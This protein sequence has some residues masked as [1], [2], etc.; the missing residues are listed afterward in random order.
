MINGVPITT[1]DG[2]QHLVP[3]YAVTEWWEVG[4]YP[5]RCGAWV[6][7]AAM[8]QPV[9]TRCYLCTPGQTP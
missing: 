1:H 3:D 7:A 6:P 8:T 9:R 4:V 5:A 2:R